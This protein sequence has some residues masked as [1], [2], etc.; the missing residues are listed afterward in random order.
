MKAIINQDG[1]Y[2]KTN[3]ILCDMRNIIDASQQRAYQ[4]ANIALVQRNWLSM[5]KIWVRIA[6]LHMEWKS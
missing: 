4:L 1:D 6:G 2:V 5:R 3:D